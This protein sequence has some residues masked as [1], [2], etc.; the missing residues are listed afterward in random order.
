VKRKTE[1]RREATLNHEM[2][3]IDKEDSDYLDKDF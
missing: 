2:T 1:D 3:E